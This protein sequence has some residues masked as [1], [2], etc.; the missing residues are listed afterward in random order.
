[1]SIATL[2]PSDHFLQSLFYEETEELCAAV[3]K[4]AKVYPITLHN[5]MV[6]LKCSLVY[7]SYSQHSLN[8]LG[9]PREMNVCD[10]TVQTMKGHAMMKLGSGGLTYTCSCSSVSEQGWTKKWLFISS[11]C[12][13]LHTF[14]LGRL[15]NW[16]SWHGESLEQPWLS[17][18]CLHNHCNNCPWHE[19][20]QLPPQYLY[21][22][23]CCFQQSA[24]PSKPGRDPHG[25]VSQWT[26]NHSSPFT[27]TRP[28]T[29]LG[30]CPLR[31]MLWVLCRSLLKAERS[32]N[33]LPV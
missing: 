12:Q 21:L 24:L 14:N 29:S 30:E 18:R 28:S 19:I 23:A 16:S 27:C 8:H 1:M 11:T 17:S 5:T 20:P 4:V 15:C 25:M 33:T 13:S 7:Q 9:F 22:F 31:Q 6:T 32:Y 2:H 3:V 10:L 26:M